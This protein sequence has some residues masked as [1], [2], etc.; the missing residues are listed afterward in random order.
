M[1][2]EQEN[3]RREMN[4]CVIMNEKQLLK[5]LT[6]HY[7]IEN[8]TLNLL[9]K[10]GGHTYIVNG[11]SKYLLKVIETALWLSGDNNR[12]ACSAEFK[13]SRSEVRTV[14]GQMD[15]SYCSQQSGRTG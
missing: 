10:S 15:T 2:C 4:G 6:T 5:I 1:A 14:S 8:S 7:G 12:T 13:T 3:D 9:R 11:E